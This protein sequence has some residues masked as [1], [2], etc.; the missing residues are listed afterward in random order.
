MNLIVSSPKNEE[1]ERERDIKRAIPFVDHRLLDLSVRNWKTTSWSVPVHI[2]LLRRRSILS[3]D[4]RYILVR[5]RY[6]YIDLEWAK[7]TNRD[8]SLP[9]KDRERENSLNSLLNLQ[10]KH[11]CKDDWVLHRQTFVYQDRQSTFFREDHEPTKLRERVRSLLS[12]ERCLYLS[13]YS[14]Q[15][16]LEII[17]R[18]IIYPTSIQH[19]SVDSRRNF[20]L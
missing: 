4:Q 6:D 8:R 3:I 9:L 15:N 17:D 16:R 1:R 7:N 10:T 18:E 5:Q 11:W 12:R 2:E 20:S 19:I 14:V 13:V